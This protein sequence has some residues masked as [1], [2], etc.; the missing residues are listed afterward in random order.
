[1]P[2]PSGESVSV[3]Y[4]RDRPWSGYSRY[5]GSARSRIEVNTSFPI[6]VDRVLDLACHE[7]Y[8]GHHVYSTL[9]D[10]RVVDARHWP[11]Y[12]VMPLFSP[13]SFVAEATASMGAA[14]VFSNADR[15][16]F[17]RDVLFPLAGLDPT[18]AERYVAVTRL[19]EHLDLP[20]AGIVARY[21]TGDLDFVEAGWALKDE[22]LMAHPLATLQFVNQYRGYALAYTL[23][24]AQL[25]PVIG[26][27]VPS[28]VRWENFIG[29]IEGDLAEAPLA[30]GGP[31]EM[32]VKMERDGDYSSER[33]NQQKSRDRVFR[34]P[35][36]ERRAALDAAERR[37]PVRVHRKPRPAG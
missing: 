30:P 8:P 12:S 9:R 4:V 35:G 24:K 32:P 34:R 22:A 25:T 31:P 15:L 37:D 1:V 16:A 2:L 23:G 21:L 28:D 20:L 11:E 18:H 14:M 5:L 19:R 10:R 7:G 27:D 6:T 29:L 26:P 17:E 3:V 36:H 13:E 33:S